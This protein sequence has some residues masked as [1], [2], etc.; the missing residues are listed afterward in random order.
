MKPLPIII[1]ILLVIMAENCNFLGD[2]SIY[3]TR[4][5]IVSPNLQKNCS[6]AHPTLQMHNFASVAKF[7]DIIHCVISNLESPVVMHFEHS[8]LINQ[9]TW[10]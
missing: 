2:L 9:M 7:H 5:Q 6:K 3:L 10:G 1:P 8:S 4:R